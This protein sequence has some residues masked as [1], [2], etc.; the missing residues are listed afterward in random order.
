MNIAPNV[1]E[2]S[3]RQWAAAFLGLA[4]GMSCALLFH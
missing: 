4:C 1:G 3:I 2:L